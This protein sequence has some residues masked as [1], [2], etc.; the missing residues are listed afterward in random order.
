MHNIYI[1][2]FGLYL[3]CEWLGRVYPS[4]NSYKYIFNYIKNTPAILLI[5]A[6]IAI[7]SA[8]SLRE[9]I[10][11]E[12]D[13][14]IPALYQINTLS[15]REHMSLYSNTLPLFRVNQYL[16]VLI[17]AACLAMKQHMRMWCLSSTTLTIVSP[18][19]LWSSVGDLVLWTLMRRVQFY[20]K[21]KS[22]SLN[23]SK[24]QNDRKMKDYI[25]SFWNQ[26]I[27]LLYTVKPAQVI[28]SIKQSPVLKG[29]IFLVMSQKIPYQLN[30]FKRP[31]VLK[32]HFSLSQRWPFNT[33]L[34][35][36]TCFEHIFV[37]I[38]LVACQ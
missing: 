34:T 5:T 20:F 3:V 17:T 16:I 1:Q 26:Y 37:I 13:D 2:S 4:I 35:V 15:Q 30:L 11:F 8:I 25:C 21:N 29:H 38:K 18:M 12:L 31:P 32:G 7:C 36:F 22:L 14:E 28:T 10:T 6:K 33:G 27:Y 19:W 23:C 9:P 24:A